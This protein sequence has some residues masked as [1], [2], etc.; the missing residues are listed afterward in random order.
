MD[1]KNLTPEFERNIIIDVEGKNIFGNSEHITGEIYST[2][3]E[4]WKN[5]DICTTMRFPVMA[6]SNLEFEMVGEWRYS[7]FPDPIHETSIVQGDFL[8][9]TRRVNTLEEQV[10]DLRVK[11]NRLEK[12]IDERDD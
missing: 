4:I 5:N 12:R 6:H 7:K 10:R 1:K 8:L 3:K 2:L 9:L 11:Y